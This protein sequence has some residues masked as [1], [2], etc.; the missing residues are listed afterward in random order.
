M[1]TAILKSKGMKKSKV[2]LVVFYILIA[3]ALIWLFKKLKQTNE[4]IKVSKE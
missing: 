3:V 4:A 1:F 2:F